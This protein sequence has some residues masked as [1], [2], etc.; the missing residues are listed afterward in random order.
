MLGDKR[1][2]DQAMARPVAWKLRWVSLLIAGLALACSLAPAKAEPIQIKDIMGREVTLDA[3]ARRIVLGAGRHLSVMALIHRDPASLV[4]GWR[5]DFRR[6]TASLA[7]WAEKF[8]RVADIPVIG[9]VAGDGLAV[10]TIVGL[11]PDLV[12]LSLYDA[13]APATARS[14]DM[15]TQL[16]IPVLVLDFF[17]HP[18]ENSLPS[19]KMLGHA[20]GAEERADAFAAFYSSHLERVRSRL[21]SGPLDR[22]GVFMHVHA[23]GMPCCST[24]GHGVFNEM[25]ELAGGRNLALD[26]VPGLYGDV[27]LEQLIVDDPQIYIATGGAHLAARGGLVLGPGIDFETARKSFDRLLGSVGIAELTAVREG[28][29]YALWH[30]FNDSPVHIVMIEQLARIFHPDRFGDLDPQETIEVINRDFLA[31]PMSGVYWLE[32]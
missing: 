2:I 12:I 9:G 3:S 8:P 11:S 30:M 27:S 26:H 5:D 32:Q 17:S 7:A 16:G 4:V 24:P 22:P 20:I 21:A 28:R 15:L 29:A 25:I 10:E 13:E 19:L 14:I 6:D 31:V 23:G 1:G 18:L